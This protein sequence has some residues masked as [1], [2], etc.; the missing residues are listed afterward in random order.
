[1]RGKTISHYRMLEK[2]GGGGMG[3]VYKALDTRLHR[4]VALKFLPEAV[5]HDAHALARF[6]REARAASALNH[7]NICTI[8]DVGEAQGE[9]FIAM[10]Y[11]DGHTL[12]HVIDDQPMETARLLALAIETAE[13]LEAAHSAG[14]IHRDIKPA[15]IFV[16]ARGHAKILDFGLAK[17]AP[18]ARGGAPGSGEDT[19]SLETDQEALTK[20]GMAMGTASYMSPEQAR[21]EKLD[22]RTDLFSFGAVLYEMATGQRAFP[23]AN[24]PDILLALLQKEPTPP[25]RFNP[26]IPPH[27]ERII[28]R[29]LEKERTRRYPSAAEMLA[30]LKSLGRER[31]P[32][33]AALAPGEI[34]SPDPLRVSVPHPVPH[35]SSR[36]HEFPKAG[37]R[38]RK[39]FLPRRLA[40]HFAVACL[41]IFGLQIWLHHAVDAFGQ[42]HNFLTQSI[43]GLEDFYHQLV[44]ASPR[45]PAP[46]FTS[47]VTLS[48][49][50]SPAGVSFFSVCT[51][52]N[53]LGEVL[54][55]LAHAKVRVVVIDKNFG[56]TSCAKDDPGTLNLMRGV[57]ALCDAHITL[58]VGREVEEVARSQA[59][60]G[61]GYPL[62]PS[63]S[64]APAACVTESVINIHPDLR[65]VVLWWPNVQPVSG[66]RNAPPT[67]AL[68]ASLAASPSFLQNGR[69]AGWTPDAPVP[70]V[71]FVRRGQ[72]DDY[73]I[74]ARDLV[75]SAPG[76][77]GWR[78]CADAELSSKVRSLADGRIII[79]G[80]D[81]PGYD[82]FD[83]V[84]GKMPGYI[85]QA[86]YIE[87]LL[88]DRLIR[89]V[90][91]G[92]NVVA[93][94][95][96][97]AAFEYLAWRHHGR[98]LY[99][100]SSIALLV[101]GTALV[102]Y[103]SV[104][105][106]GYYL[107]PATIGLLAVL[108][109]LAYTALAPAEG[110]RTRVQHS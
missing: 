58:V 39:P 45:K 36:S 64:F 55:T 29:A 75:C 31:D 43:F 16:T 59:A 1:M 103:L 30:D 34:P 47:L 56:D 51:E 62:A 52:R 78:A 22:A 69:L 38:G 106:L 79:I 93:G 10:E 101:V 92:L 24:I 5:A 91:A 26:G 94:L 63:L 104:T 21:S 57:Q 14:I 95:M 60:P 13:A 76:N 11:L 90:P 66:S 108:L 48:D 86:N 87:S 50:S 28:D 77:P 71:S 12:K 33:G 54:K 97:F 105:L 68:A 67:L 70:Y 37:I 2:L 7:P 88:D 19:R 85:L 81:R 23:G 74:A 25:R 72:F 80:E 110:A 42:S 89:P 6:T 9:A 109:R 61:G 107:N 20:P 44:T 17:V 3:V 15:N 49:T 27:L 98:R 96:F 32:L 41:L 8:Y 65:R 4:F 73:N 100:L 83:T 99:A 82:S 53:F 35:E 18:T 84:V 102:I 46:R 40:I